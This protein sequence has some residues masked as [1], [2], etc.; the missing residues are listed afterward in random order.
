MIWNLAQECGKVYSLALKE[1]MHV[2]E[3]T[4]K[5][6]TYYELQKHM[7]GKVDKKLLHSNSFLASIQKVCDNNKAWGNATK[8]NPNSIYLAP[9]KSKFI[10]A[11]YF[12]ESQITIGKDNILK[13]SLANREYTGS[14]KYFYIKWN[15]DIPK[16]KFGEITYNNRRGWKIHLMIDEKV[17]Q[18]KYDQ[19]QK[20]KDIKILS[21]DLGVKRIATFY[22]GNNC[23]TISGKK[24]LGLTHYQNSLFKKT[25]SKLNS[26]ISGSKNYKKL[27][28]SFRRK[29]DRLQNIKNDYLHK[30]SNVIVKHSLHNNITNIVIGNSSGTHHLNLGG[31]T[32]KIKT[33]PEQRLKKLINYKFKEHGGITDIIPEPYTSRTC[34]CCK[35]IKNSSPSGR[36]YKC[37]ECGY[38]YDRDGVGAVNIYSLYVFEHLIKKYK[39]INVLN[40]N[41][42]FGTNA[43][44]NRLLSRPFGVKFH[45]GKLLMDNCIK[46]I[47]IANYKNSVRNSNLSK[48]LETLRNA[49]WNHYDS[50]SW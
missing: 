42:S 1:H 5:W 6:M 38:I 3:E 10:H 34:I 23:V 50:Y 21:V 27:E 16:P 19:P 7:S 4:G 32:I 26:K 48:E 41:V 44:R 18:L 33:F 29:N 25:K 35:N 22:D 13:I 20:I 28:R 2:H 31:Q 12:K 9:Y 47:S 46:A 39:L 30:I 36:T 11:I 49:R 15:S 8:G 43:G 14:D 37:S 24:M 45:S 17:E 40:K